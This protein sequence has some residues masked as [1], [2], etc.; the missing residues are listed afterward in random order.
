MSCRVAS[1]WCCL[2]VCAVLVHTAPAFA[3]PGAAIGGGALPKAR[4]IE[5]QVIP[6][7]R[8][9]PIARHYGVTSDNLVRWNKLDEE[10]PLIRVGQKLRV[11]TAME[12]LVRERHVHVV[13]R[14][15]SWSRIASRYGVDARTMRRLW[16][17]KLSKDLRAGQ[18][19]VVW[20]EPEP[21]PEEEGPSEVDTAEV[22]SPR[23]DLPI[24]PVPLSA[25]SI[26]R[27]DRGRISRAIQLPVNDALY[28]IRKPEAS[29]GSSHT[30]MQLQRGIA[31]FRA[32]TG[33]DREIV[34]ADMSRKNGGRF[35]PHRSHRSGR[36]VDI[37]LPLA[38]GIAKG[39][40]PMNRSDVDW[41]AAW[42]L[43][44]ALIDTGEVHYIFLSRNRQ[45]ALLGAAQ[46]AG[47]SEEA[48]TQLI[49]YPHRSRT[50]VVRH[51]RGHIKHFHVRFK[52]ASYETACGD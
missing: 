25:L 44:K 48:L 8:L 37:R 19:L 43:M 47:E 30:V 29:F 4:W 32:A 31:S 22:P 35:R 6:G 15:E 42:A 3:V 14:G 13:K 51:S 45:S 10:R 33:F 36:D 23:P 11:Y 39:T 18:K 27:P 7:E 40:I 5:H 50:A 41:D 52:C 26:G 17:P 46:R 1:P 2:L 16:N 38:K 24:V 34:V 9:A 28:T 21:E 20:V 49:Q 12:P